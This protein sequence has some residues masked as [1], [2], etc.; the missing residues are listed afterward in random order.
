MRE[1]N[2]TVD[3]KDNLREKRSKVE[4]AWDEESDGDDELKG[5]LTSYIGKG[6]DE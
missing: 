3:V 1:D 6:K 4:K 2:D 5:I